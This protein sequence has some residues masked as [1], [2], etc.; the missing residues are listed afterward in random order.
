MTRATAKNTLHR[1]NLL[2]TKIEKQISEKIKTADQI[3]GATCLKSVS[4]T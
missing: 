2:P 1:S 3:K 4:N